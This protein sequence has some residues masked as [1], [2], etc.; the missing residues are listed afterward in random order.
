MRLRLF[1]P[2]E[3]LSFLSPDG[4]HGGLLLRWTVSG[5]P[6]DYYFPTRRIK[7]EGDIPAVLIME[8][9]GIL[10]VIDQNCWGYS[11]LFTFFPSYL[12]IEK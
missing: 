3:G 4:Y 11:L 8:K 9:V 12:L 10:N 6:S 5:T 7:P 1:D 2:G